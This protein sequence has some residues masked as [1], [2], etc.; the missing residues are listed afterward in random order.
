MITY[1]NKNEKDIKLILAKNLEGN[2]YIGA[3]DGLY[4]IYEIKK[5]I[6]NNKYFLVVK[7]GVVFAND[8]FVSTICS[9]DTARVLKSSEKEWNKFQ[10]ED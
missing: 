5:E 2:E 9:E 6:R 4:Q 1:E 8:L 10:E 7:G 3:E